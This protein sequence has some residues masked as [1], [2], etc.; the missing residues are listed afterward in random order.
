[1]SYS[2]DVP[3]VSPTSSASAKNIAAEQ[4]QAAEEILAVEI[5]EAEESLFGGGDSSF[6]PMYMMKESKKLDEQLKKHAT[7]Q[8]EEADDDDIETKLVDDV[9]KLARSLEKKNSEMNHK[10]LLGLKADIKETDDAETIYEKV[11]KYYKDEFLADE[12]LKFIEEITNPHTKHGQNVRQARMLLNARH[13]RAVRAGRNINETAQ[14]FQ[15]QGLATAGSLRELYKDVTKTPKEPTTLFEELNETYSFAK[16]K[17][18]LSF[19]LHSLGKDMKSKGPSITVA[20][21]TRLFAETR[22]MQAILSIYKFFHSRMNLIK[23]SLER[24][25]L[26]LPKNLNFE[27]LAKIFGKYIQE[28]YPSPDKVLRLSSQ[29]GLDEEIIAQII[30]FTQYRDA[31]RGVSPKLFRSLKHRQELLM[32]LIETISELD[33]LLE[34]EEDD[35]EDEEEEKPKGWSNKDTME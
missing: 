7:R 34:E 9:T 20:E 22:T 6:S 25:N 19:L 27:Q 32:A 12:A 4:A 35:E 33:D 1:M 30:I 16:M 31:L 21:L 2:S 11:R 14:E 17:Q 13:Q 26:K 8:A 5:E 15:R 10:A 28:R 3:G 18:V 24:E 29:L 23:E